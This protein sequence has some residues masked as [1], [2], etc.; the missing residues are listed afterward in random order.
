MPPVSSSPAAARGLGA[1]GP[2]GYFR[3]AAIWRRTR[4]TNARHAATSSSSAAAVNTKALERFLPVKLAPRDYG[5][6]CSR[7]RSS[8]A[9][10]ASMNCATSILT[11]DVSDAGLADS[12]CAIAT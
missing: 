1:D 12:A 4:S 11:C 9:A 3:T 5:V 8:S 6:D 7:R 2:T 10:Q